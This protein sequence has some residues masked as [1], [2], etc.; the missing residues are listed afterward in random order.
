MGRCGLTNQNSLIIWDASVNKD[1]LPTYKARQLSDSKFKMMSAGHGFIAAITDKGVLVIARA[2]SFEI[3]IIESLLGLDCIH[4]EAAERSLYILSIE[5][6][7]WKVFDDLKNH[8][9]KQFRPVVIPVPRPVKIATLCGGVDAICAITDE[10]CCFVLGKNTENRLLLENINETES[11]IEIKLGFKVKK[12]G[13]GP[14]NSALISEN[15]SLF[16]AGTNKY[17]ALGDSF[18]EGRTLVKRDLPKQVVDVSVGPHYTC[19]I[20]R[21]GTVWTWGRAVRGQLGRNPDPQDSPR[22]VLFNSFQ[23]LTALSI[24]TYDGITLLS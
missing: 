5:G 3:E 13:I 11:L 24:S 17:G 23:N 19:A 7:I 1:G 16:L 9:A 21:D 8:S 14:L 6:E 2:P 18:S 22:Q 15:G 10:G 12:M 20:C 4:C